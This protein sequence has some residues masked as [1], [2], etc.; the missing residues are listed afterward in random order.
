MDCVIDTMELYELPLNDSMDNLIDTMDTHQPNVF[1]HLI[2]PLAKSISE[3]K[4]I[5]TSKKFIWHICEILSVFLIKS[6]LT[7]PTTLMM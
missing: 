1:V 4:K 2:F 3:S 7:E 6:D 5:M